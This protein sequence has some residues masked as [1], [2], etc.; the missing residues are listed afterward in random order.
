[1]RNRIVFYFV[2][3]VVWLIF[4]WKATPGNVLA[5]AIASLIVTL[6]MGDLFT[7]HAGKFIQVKRYFWLLYFIPVFLWEV[8]KSNFDVAYRVLHP[9]LKI[10]PGIVKVKTNIK[11]DSGLTFLVSAISL[12][13]G[14]LAVDVDQKNG[15]IYVHWINVKTQDVDKA[16]ELIITRFERILSRIYE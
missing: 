9:S 6:V 3:L 13:P 1:M 14:T 7:R 16:T 8:I 5:G 11:S 4:T 15:Y 12:T 2:A 10:N